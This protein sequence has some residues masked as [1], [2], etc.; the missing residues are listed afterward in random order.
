M[1]F[2]LP[3]TTDVQAARAIIQ[4]D[5]VTIECSFLVGSQSKGCYVN[6]I[7]ANIT[8]PLRIERVNGSNFVQLTYT[9]SV[10]ED[11]DEI[12]VYDWESDGSIG[13]LAIP[14]EVQRLPVGLDPGAVLL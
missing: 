1:Q 3:D 11:L 4:T 5:S 6:L 12:L 9:L 2:T 7:L 13:S 14:L 8:T 10:E